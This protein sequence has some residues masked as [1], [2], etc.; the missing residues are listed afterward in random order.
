V[1][2]AD[3]RWTDLDS[4]VTRGWWALE[5][6]GE[7]LALLQPFDGRVSIV[8]Y[9]S[10]QPWAQKQGSAG[11]MGQAKRFT[12][13]WLAPRLRQEIPTRHAVDAR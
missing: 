1:L 2:P 10:A 13:R 8:F 5:L 3:C 12:E 6:A 7:R 9:L 11:T 4:P